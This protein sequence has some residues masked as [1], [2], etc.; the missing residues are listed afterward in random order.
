MYEALVLVVVVVIM[1]MMY[2][3]NTDVVYIENPPAP[4]VEPW[5]WGTGWPSR[6]VRWQRYG[7]GRRRHPRYGRRWSRR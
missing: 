5:H 1:M 3:K 7:G 2:K 4:A 6:G